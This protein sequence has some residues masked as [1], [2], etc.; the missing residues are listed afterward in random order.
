MDETEFFDWCQ[1]IVECKSDK[2]IS[3]YKQAILDI[4]NI[5]GDI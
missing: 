1:K 3:K 5:L 4:K 2:I